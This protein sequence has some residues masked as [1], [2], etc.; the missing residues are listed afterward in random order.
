MDVSRPPVRDGAAPTVGGV[1]RRVQEKKGTGYLN[2]LQLFQLA[3]V[4]N[5]GGADDSESNE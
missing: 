2:F 1:F 4:V 3:M 5:S